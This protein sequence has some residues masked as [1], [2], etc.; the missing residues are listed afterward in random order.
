M[1]NISTIA[2]SNDF[3]HVVLARRS[4]KEYVPTTQISKEEMTVILEKATKAPSS[5]NLQPWHIIVVDSPEGKQQLMSISA[6][7][8]AD[9][10]NSASATIAIFGDLQSK[11]KVDDIYQR[12][13]ELGYMPAEVRDRIIPGSKAWLNQLSAQELRD[14]MMTDA[15]LLAMQ[16]MLVARSHGYGTNPIAGYDKTK[17]NEL[18]DLDAE[19][20]VPVMI[21]TIGE[22]TENGKDGF[23]SIRQ[24][25]EEVVTWK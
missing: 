6:S 19:R 15:G 25:I 11:E 14:I 16:F 13:V 18:F 1:S 17:I 9:K 10:I 23:P 7:V 24:P 5:V 20:F 2:S 4:I 22:A 21:I 8:N 12:T 3:N